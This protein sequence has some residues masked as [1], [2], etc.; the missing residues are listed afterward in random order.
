MI[1]F[2]AIIAICSFPVSQFIHNGPYS[3]VRSGSPLE[4]AHQRAVNSFVEVDNFGLSRFKRSVYWNET[5]ITHD[6][7]DFILGE[8]N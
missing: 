7:R 2:G 1:V 6:E 5:A 8:I 4:Q 3:G